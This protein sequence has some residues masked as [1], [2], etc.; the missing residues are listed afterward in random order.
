[1]ANE[2]KMIYCE[3]RLPETGEL[4]KAELCEINGSVVTLKPANGRKRVVDLRN[5]SVT[6]DICGFK[7]RVKFK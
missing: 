5:N 3:G 7:T 1:M 2:P 6:C 4:C